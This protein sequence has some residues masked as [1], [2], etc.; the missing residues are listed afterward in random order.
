MT[1]TFPGGHAL[2]HL[3]QLTG[4][5]SRLAQLLPHANWPMGQ[6]TPHRPMPHTFPGGHTVPHVPQLE[7]SDSTLTQ[8]PPQFT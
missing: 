4:S 6:E 7:P 1:H 8:A 5:L 2:S 3:P